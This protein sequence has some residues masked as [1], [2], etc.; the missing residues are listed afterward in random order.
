MTQGAIQTQH[1][2]R[3]QKTRHLFVTRRES[4]VM[5]SHKNIWK[6]SAAKAFLC[7]ECQ[8]IVIDYS[9]PDCDLNYSQ[10]EPDTEYG[11]NSDN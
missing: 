8:K 4:D 1:E 2:L 11:E 3:W 10:P 6:G 5:L 7:R 9:T